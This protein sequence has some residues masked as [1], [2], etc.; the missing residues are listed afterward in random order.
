M[1][2]DDTPGALGSDDQLGPL[3]GGWANVECVR[4]VNRSTGQRTTET[5]SRDGLLDLMRAVQAAARERCIAAAE[6]AYIA[7][8]GAKGCID[9]I[10]VLCGPNVRAETDPTAGAEVSRNA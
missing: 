8:K 2:Q 4:F 5:V 7:G 1:P 9:A 3:L 6:D 10:R